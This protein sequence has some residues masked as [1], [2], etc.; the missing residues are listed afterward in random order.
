MTKQVACTSIGKER[1]RLRLQSFLQICMMRITLE[2]LFSEKQQ[3]LLGKNGIGRYP[4]MRRTQIYI[5]CQLGWNRGS[6]Y[7]SRP[8]Q[9]QGDEGFFVV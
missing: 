9:W 8:L 5:L 3:C 2:R 6:L 4:I 7:S 1:G